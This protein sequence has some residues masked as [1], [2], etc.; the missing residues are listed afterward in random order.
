MRAGIGV[1]RQDDVRAAAAEAAGRALAQAGLSE[2]GFL[3]VAGSPHHLDEAIDLGAALR[4]AAGARVRIVGGAAASVMAWAD[5]AEEGPAL[6]VLALEG[7]CLPFSF[8]PGAPGSLQAAARAAGT[9][10]LGL[11]FADTAASLPPLFA[12][13][14]RE[15]P[16]V[17]FAGGGVAA[18]GGLLL[19]D[20]LEEAAAVGLIVPG[21]ARVGVA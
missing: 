20:D 18:E 5:D 1:S 7:P 19:D 10:A 17:R 13:L 4:A 2:A 16:G 6:G 11:V 12:A 21:G 15:A 14:S 9:D 8:S 3:F